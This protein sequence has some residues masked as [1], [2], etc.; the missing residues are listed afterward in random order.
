MHIPENYIS[1]STCAVMG[2]AMIPVWTHAIKNVKKNISKDK[3]P[4]IGVGAAFSF[5]AMMFNVPLLGGTTGH[6]VGGT[7]IALMF[8]PDAA[9]IAV[10]IALLI[11]AIIFG[12]GGIL[13]LGANCFNMAFIL[14]YTGFYL[15]KLFKKIF[16]KENNVREI[17]SVF[18]ASYI[19]INLAALFTSV[20]LGIQPY[21]FKDTT[22]LPMYC[23]YGLDVSIP[24]IMVSHLLIAGIVEGLFTVGIY[25]FVKKTSPDLIYEEEIKQENKNTKHFPVFA[26]ISALIILTPLG[27][28][29][30]GTAWG[31]WG[32]DEINEMIGYVPEG[33]NSWSLEALL[34]DYALEGQ[35]EILMYILS[36]IIGVAL[37][38][39]IFKILGFILGKKD[40]SNLA[41]N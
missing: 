8:G 3:I 36:A 10:S 29:A 40:D 6:A 33:M 41:K 24:A 14:P 30:S 18:L 35:N 38:I 37:I 19:A 25:A 16:G 27:L 32:A 28:L 9:C 34:P 2:V 1:P 4:M 7:L 21:L 22:G 13:S 26:L 39:I 17:I 23:P 11:Q 20:E 31:E 12:D 5:L 15:Y